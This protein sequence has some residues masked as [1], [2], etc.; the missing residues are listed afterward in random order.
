[1]NNLFIKPFAFEGSADNSNWTT[2]VPSY[3]YS[4]NVFGFNK[5]PFPANG[6]TFTNTNAYRYYRFR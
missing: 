2:I 5:L 6:F 3:S 4:Q 1:M